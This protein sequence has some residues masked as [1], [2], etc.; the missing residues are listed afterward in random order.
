MILQHPGLL[1]VT[2]TVFG[3]CIWDADISCAIHV[4]RPGQQIHA[5]F[6]IFLQPLLGKASK[7]VGNPYFRPGGDDPYGGVPFPGVPFPVLTPLK[8]CGC[9]SHFRG[10]FRSNVRRLH[11]FRAETCIPLVCTTSFFYT[12]FSLRSLKRDCVAWMHLGTM[13]KL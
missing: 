3:V 11:I 5:P 6:A 4:R 10:Q 1:R 13:L 2:E 7:F 8:L 9:R 12:F